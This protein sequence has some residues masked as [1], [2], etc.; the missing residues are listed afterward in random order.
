MQPAVKLG[1]DVALEWL[2]GKEAP[3]A[4]RET[5]RLLKLGKLGLVTNPS[6]VTQRLQAGADVLHRAGARVAALFGPEHGVRGEFADGARVGNS[7][8]TRTGIPLYSL[9]GETNAPT[10]EMLAGLDAIAFD[11]Q[12]VGARFYTFASTL[13][14]VMKSAKKSG[15]PVIILDRPNPLGGIE[16]EGPVLEP[17]HSSFVGRHPIPVRHGCTIGELGRLWSQ[18]G[19]GD[20]PLVVRCSGWRRSRLWP[21]TGLDWVA[22]SPNMP[23][24]ET[25]LTYPGAC[26]FEGTNVSEARGT[27]NPF[28]WFGAPW[29]EPEDTSDA[30]NGVAL[31][32]VRFRPVRFRPSSSKHVG[33]TCGGCQ[34]HITDFSRFRPVRTAVVILHH[35]RRRYDGSFRW[36]GSNGRFGVDRLVGTSLLREAAED[37]APERLAAEWQGHCEEFRVLK[38]RVSLYP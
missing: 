37:G 23:T 10:D 7:V 34:I 13:G 27:A 20:E 6:A 29:L 18:F 2:S 17:K 24:F 15:I 31:P 3:R 14:L 28:R 22:P 36:L 1:L 8:D 35:L 21:A 4:E 5:A 25:A 11:I 16:I 32:G 30:L 38:E 9:Y 19:D 26:F 33:L 12:D